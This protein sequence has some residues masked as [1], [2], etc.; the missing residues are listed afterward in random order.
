MLIKTTWFHES[1]YHL[2]CFVLLCS[3]PPT[4]YPLVFMDP[5]VK[6]EWEREFI[7]AKKS[8]EVKM[9]NRRVASLRSSSAW[10]TLNSLEF[11]NPLP[12]QP[13]RMGMKVLCVFGN[14][15]IFLIQ[16]VCNTPH[17]V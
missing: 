1:N 12:L 13:G 4:Q 11:L 17:S 3:R 16:N 9:K 2:N 15:C 6:Q 10:L 8:A 7:E 14:I 5:K